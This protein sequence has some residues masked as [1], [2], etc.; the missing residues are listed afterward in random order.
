MINAMFNSTSVTIFVNLC[1]TLDANVGTTF[2]KV[3]EEENGRKGEGYICY[4]FQAPD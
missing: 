2:N 4:Q 1:N 3:R